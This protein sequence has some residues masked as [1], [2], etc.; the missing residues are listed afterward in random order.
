M[1][2]FPRKLSVHP[3]RKDH[4]RS[5]S[6]KVSGPRPRLY[7]LRTLDVGHS[8]CWMILQAQAHGSTIALRRLDAR[9]WIGT[10][11]AF[12]NEGQQLSQVLQILEGFDTC[13]YSCACIYFGGYS[14]Q[15]PTRSKQQIQLLFPIN[16]QR[17][18]V[19]NWRNRP[20]W[21]PQR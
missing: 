1:I 21:S 15:C 16:R 5:E 4:S 6:S 20:K 19:L 2:S 17:L 14:S 8:I 3:L 10:Y 7:L 11:D 18:H 9:I 12:S 13:H